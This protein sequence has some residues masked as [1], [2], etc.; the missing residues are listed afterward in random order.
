MRCLTLS[1]CYPIS[2]SPLPDVWLLAPL[3]RCVARHAVFSAFQRK[4]A[5]Q[6]CLR[7]CPMC[8]AV[9]SAFQHECGPAARCL[10][11][12][13][14]AAA[15]GCRTRQTAPR[16]ARRRRLTRARPTAASAPPPSRR[17]RPDPAPPH[18]P[19]ESQESHLF[20]PQLP[21]ESGVASTHPK[22]VTGVTSRHPK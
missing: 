15:A 9:C 11:A 6:S 21:C 3:V 20:M 12:A 5:F 8:D 4:T 17:R 14:A 18:A 22:R 19:S 13:A 2:D 16:R 7:P 1:A 10:A